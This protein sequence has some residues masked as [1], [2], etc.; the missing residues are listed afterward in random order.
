MKIFVLFSSFLF[1]EKLSIYPFSFD[2]EEAVFG[3]IFF[4]VIK[5]LL[6]HSSFFP[7]MSSSF[8]KLDAF[9]S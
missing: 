4:L 2:S 3:L 1:S 9:F 6:F 5:I 7:Q 8:G